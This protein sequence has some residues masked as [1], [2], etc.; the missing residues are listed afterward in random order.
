MTNVCVE[1]IMLSLLIPLSNFLIDIILHVWLQV[2]RILCH[3]PCCLTN[4]EASPT[5][6]EETSLKTPSFFILLRWSCLIDLSE[7]LRPE[8][9]CFVCTLKSTIEMRLVRQSWWHY[10]KPHV[11]DWVWPPFGIWFVDR[12]IHAN[13]WKTTE[14]WVWVWGSG[15][16]GLWENFLYSRLGPNNTCMYRNVCWIVDNIL[17]IY[18]MS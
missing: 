17:F 4:M 11:V 2:N 8:T 15:Y 3:L 13:G 10:Y 9:V 6:I 1:S 14:F 18:L 16:W 5:L 7:N 12:F